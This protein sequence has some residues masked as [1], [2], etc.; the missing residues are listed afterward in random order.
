M[1]GIDQLIEL[2]YGNSVTEQTE[3][4]GRL[5]LRLLGAYNGMKRQEIIQE[6]DLEDN[7]ADPGKKLDDI[8]SPLRGNKGHVPIQAVVSEQRDGDTYYHLS[9]HALT[10]SFNSVKENVKYVMESDNLQTEI[11]PLKSSIRDLRS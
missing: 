2:C 5:V 4:E 3:K 10:S 8:L 11:E 7:Y 1:R 6:L 9:V